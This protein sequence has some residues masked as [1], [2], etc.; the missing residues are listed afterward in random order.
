[1]WWSIDSRIDSLWLRSVLDFAVTGTGG[2]VESSADLGVAVVSNGAS[3]GAE[4]A[5]LAWSG[6]IGEDSSPEAIEQAAR[7]ARQMV[8]MLDDLLFTPRTYS[9]SRWVRRLEMG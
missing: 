5:V 8:L 2:V 3:S 6:A 7:P 9:W 1:M 4:L